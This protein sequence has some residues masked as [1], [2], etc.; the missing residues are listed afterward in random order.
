VRTNRTA[1][2][3]PGVLPKDLAEAYDA[4]A[5]AWAVGPARVYDRLASVLVDRSPVP[6]AGRL[7]LDVGAGTGAAGRAV[8]RAGGH[9]LAVDLSAAML[10]ADPAAAG[11]AV[12]ADA[13]RLPVADAGVDGLVAAFSFNHL[14]EPADGMA[15][16]RRVCRPGS[17][18]LVAAYAADDDHPVKAAVDRAAAEAGWSPA[19]WYRELRDAVSARLSTTAGMAAAADRAGLGGAVV[20]HVVVD[21]AALT[22]A[23]LVA[24][25]LGMAQVAPFLAGLDPAARQRVAARARALLGGD[26]PPLRRSLV[27]LAAVV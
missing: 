18:V 5:A 6:L 17:P 19:G 26:P 10:R 2:R 8:R 16:A 23:D 13:R 7:V 25:R 11:R 1:H 4:T 27:V 20:D 24:W 15:E 21:L 12:V 14:P 9:P 22:V 3:S